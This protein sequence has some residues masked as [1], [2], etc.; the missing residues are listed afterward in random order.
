MQ[1]IPL[2]TL[3]PNH[4]KNAVAMAIEQILTT[5]RVPPTRNNNVQFAISH[6]LAQPYILDYS[7][8]IGAKTFSKATWPLKSTFSV[9]N[10]NILIFLSEFQIRSE[11]F[12]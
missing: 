1:Q 12:R 4:L 9:K 5:Q 7:S 2:K 3:I 10:P 6:A 11:S 8:G